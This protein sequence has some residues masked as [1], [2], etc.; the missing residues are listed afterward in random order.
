M[1]ILIVEDSAEDIE[2]LQIAFQQSGMN[3]TFDVAEDGEKA[4]HS[5][6]QKKPDLVILDLNLPKKNGHEVLQDMKANPK[7]REIPVIVLTTTA[8]EQ[9][10]E[11]VASYPYVRFLTKPYRFSEYK[12]LLDCV[13]EFMPQIKV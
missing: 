9:D 3:H 4:L 2:L 1:R 7:L 5:F 6:A 11:K 12:Y 10:I 13:Q 8:Q